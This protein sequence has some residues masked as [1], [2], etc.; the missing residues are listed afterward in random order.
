MMKDFSS[1]DC[2]RFLVISIRIAVFK[3]LYFAFTD[4]L[5]NSSA[6]IKNVRGAA[7]VIVASPRITTR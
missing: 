7:N 6:S 4:G 2:D 5:G 1:V 3:L